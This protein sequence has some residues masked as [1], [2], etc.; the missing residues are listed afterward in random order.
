MAVEDVDVV[1]AEPRQRLVEGGQDVLPRAA[2]LAVGARPHVVAGLGGDHQL[3]AEPGEVGGEEPPEVLLR[4]TVGRA[5]VVGQVEVRDAA[6]E[7]AAQDRPLG[8]LGTVRAEVLPQP[9]RERRQLQPAPPRV[10]VVHRVVAV[11]GRLVVAHLLIVPLRGWWLHP[12]R[13]GRGRALVERRRRELDDVGGGCLPP[14]TGDAGAVGRADSAGLPHGVGDRGAQ[15]VALD[16][17]GRH[18][19]R[20]RPG[21]RRGPARAAGARC[22]C[23]CAPGRSPR[24]ARAPAPSWTRARTAAAASPGS[25][26]PRLRSMRRTTSSRSMPI[27]CSAAASSASSPSTYSSRQPVELG[28]RGRRARRPGRPAPASRGSPRRRAGPQAGAR[29]GS[30]PAVAS[31]A[32]ERRL[33]HDVTGR[34]G[35][36]LEHVPPLPQRRPCFL[37]TACLLTPST[38]AI[39]CQD[40]P[41]A[42]A[43]RTW[44]SSRCSSSRPQRPHRPQAG[45]RVGVGGGVGEVG[46][47]RP[48]PST[49]VDTSRSVNLG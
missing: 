13:A 30:R 6:V 22:R 44:V 34:L 27:A 45:A 43:R 49:Y 3:V 29:A 39:S 7:G 2:A 24:A 47:A 4:A 40:Q 46:R 11:L 33:L 21:R 42:R 35:E 37:C 14:A 19:C 48:W 23:S 1:Q 28:A 12:S 8:L 38:S 10:A 17:E 32:S 41:W 9:E 15:G 5:V 31:R 18:A 20:A 36:P 16:P 25:A 26:P